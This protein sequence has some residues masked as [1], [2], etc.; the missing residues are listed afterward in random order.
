MTAS[1]SFV[2]A[3]VLL[4]GLL[5]W[6]A[7]ASFLH[8]YF[9]F[10]LAVSVVGAWGCWRS[11]DEDWPPGLFFFALLVGPHF[12]YEAEYGRTAWTIADASVG[13]LVLLSIVQVDPGPL[14]SLFE[15][16]AWKRL[17]SLVTIVFGAAW[18]AF[19]V[20]LAYAAIQPISNIVRIK[21]DG[22]EAPARVTRVS[23]WV[24]YYDDQ[25]YDR[26][27]T[28]YVFQAEGGRMVTGTQI[29]SDDP[30]GG[31]S[32]EEFDA[33]YGGEY[34]ADETTSV[35]VTIEYQVG[36]PTNNRVPSKAGVVSAFFNAV[37]IAALGA[38]CAVVGF[39][40]CKED[41]AKLLAADSGR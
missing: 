4:A 27:R 28:E 34:I 25:Y 18:M 40:L 38:F 24:D 2:L 6:D 30:I 11:V 13:V 21:L 35:V 5:F 32:G 41:G 14:Q 26:Y 17:R 12:F 7:S 39:V 16:T 36:E 20:F 19:G 1:S 3:R 9:A 8:H 23:H 29:L 33:K 15:R 37:L 10:R 31:L 22:K